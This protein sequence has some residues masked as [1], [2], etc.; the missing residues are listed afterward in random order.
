MTST[1]QGVV[2]NISR[3][4][5]EETNKVASADSIRALIDFVCVGE[6]FALLRKTLLMYAE[7]DAQSKRD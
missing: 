2:M 5:T 1:K 3:T 7:E 6:E 4:T